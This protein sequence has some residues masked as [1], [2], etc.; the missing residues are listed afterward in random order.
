MS[1]EVKIGI[2]AAVALAVAIWGYNFI[3]G[4]NVLTSSQVFTVEYKTVDYLK[5]SSPV[6][7]NGFEIGVVT[8]IVIKPKDIH[9]LIVT[10]SISSDIPIEENTVAV[11]TDQGFLG[12]KAVELRSGIPCSERIPCVDNK[13]QMRGVT[14]SFLMSVLGDPEELGPYFKELG[15]GLNVILDSLEKRMNSNENAEGL[16]KTLN[17]LQEIVSSLKGASYSLDHLLASSNKHIRD[18]TENLS[19]L[20]GALSE[21]SQ[22]V[23]DIIDNSAVFS[24]SL[25]E[26]DLEST[27]EQANEA[28]KVLTQTL[29]DTRKTIGTFDE[30]ASKIDQGEGTIGKLFMDDSLY[31]EFLAL[32]TQADSLIS[33]LK[34][35][36]YRYIPLKNRKK[37]KKFDKQDA[38]E[39]SVQ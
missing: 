21:S 24:K 3:R 6:I 38:Q 35:R 15:S 25:S 13:N 18:I 23:S 5:V 22:G 31:D 10:L 9:R 37:I 30:L 4:R 19:Q 26:L 2:L 27:M 29:E 7:L 14:Q 33:D 20:T 34:D 8:N 12:G 11:I 36:P 16:G 32:S 39:A 17:E 1:K 28:I